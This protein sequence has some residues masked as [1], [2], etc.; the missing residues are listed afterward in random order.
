MLLNEFDKNPAKSNLS[1]RTVGNANR[2][3]LWGR[4]VRLYILVIQTWR[5]TVRPARGRQGTFP[6][7]LDENTA[8]TARPTPQTVEAVHMPAGFGGSGAQWHS[9]FSRTARPPGPL[10]QTRRWSP[11]GPAR[12][13]RRHRNLVGHLGQRAHTR[14]H[15]D[16]DRVRP[17]P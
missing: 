11:R 7:P 16:P 9:R 14:T 6:P 3:I 1:P 13:P 2:R 17:S 5:R 12:R 4:V 8:A 15:E 10:R